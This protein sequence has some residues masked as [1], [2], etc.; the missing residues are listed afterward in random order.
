MADVGH[1]PRPQVVQAK[2]SRSS[3]T[4]C[5]NSDEPS[6][7]TAGQDGNLRPNPSDFNNS[8]CEAGEARE[9]F[10]ASRQASTSSGDSVGEMNPRY[11]KDTHP[12]KYSSRPGQGGHT[13]PSW[14]RL[15]PAW[16]SRTYQ[17]TDPYQWASPTQPPV[18][19]FLYSVMMIG[20]SRIVL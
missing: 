5:T 11:P 14:G 10:P 6:S 18:G 16:S 3:A 4:S 2:L 9:A 13:S 1:D 15:H 7:T 17:P 8:S 20:P 12:P 19:R